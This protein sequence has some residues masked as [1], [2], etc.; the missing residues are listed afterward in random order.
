MTTNKTRNKRSL[1]AGDSEDQQLEFE[2]KVTASQPECFNRT[3]ASKDEM[4]YHTVE[5]PTGAKAVKVF[6]Q[7]MENSSHSID[8][9]IG[10]GSKPTLTHYDLKSSLRAPV[11]G[12]LN[13]TEYLEFVSAENLTSTSTGLPMDLYV[14]LIPIGILVSPTV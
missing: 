4:I 6:V 14:G 2:L 9:Y 1:P 7:L 5:G 8:V 12:E 3:K 13:D 10:Y 11:N